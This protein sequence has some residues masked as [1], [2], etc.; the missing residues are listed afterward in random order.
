MTRAPISAE[1]GAVEVRDELRAHG[2]PLLPSGHDVEGLAL[3]FDDEPQLA[4]WSRYAEE[5][6]RNGAFSALALVFPQLRYP[7]R[8]GISSGDGYQAAT[9][10]GVWPEDDEDA[11][12][13]RLARPDLV[14]LTIEPTLAGRIPIVVAGERRDFEDLVRAFSARNEPVAIPASMG[15]CLVRGLNNW[16]RV[17]AYRAEWEAAHA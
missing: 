10:R 8:A 12:G 11:T 16:D 9:R 13:L 17:R 5:A 3:S 14:T 15:A 1:G 4:A 7:I 6:G 2:A